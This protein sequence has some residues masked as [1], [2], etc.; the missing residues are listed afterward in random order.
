MALVKLASEAGCATVYR[1]NAAEELPR[2]ITG[3][4]GVT[5]G[6]SAP[7][8]LVRSVITCLDPRE[9]VEEISITNEDEYFP[10]PRELRELLTSLELVANALLGVPADRRATVADR[11]VAASAVLAELAP[12]T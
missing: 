2:D 4:V 7:E 9:G 3:T 6:A 5:A 11:T 12:G 1:V 8:E 10:P